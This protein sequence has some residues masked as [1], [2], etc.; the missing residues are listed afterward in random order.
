MTTA[1]WPLTE[2]VAGPPRSGW[3]DAAIYY[4]ITSCALFNFYNRWITACG[5][6]EMSP[7]AH[8]EQGR[9]LAARG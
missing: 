5:V 2:D 6:P 3:D 1:S 4:A 8:R 7:E 9:T